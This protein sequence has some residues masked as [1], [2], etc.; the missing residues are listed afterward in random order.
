M[1][2]NIVGGITQD[3]DYPQ[4][5]FALDVYSR[6][7][8]GSL[9]DHLKYSFQDEK[10]SSGEY[11][12]LRSRRPSVRHNLC[13]LVVDD[14]VA[15]LFSEGHFP[16]PVL[17]STVDRDN[18]F[19]LIK[20]ARLNEIMIDAA[21]TGSVGS[22]AIQMR[23]LKQRKSDAHKVFF[24]AHSTDFLTPQFDPACP[25]DLISIREKYKVKGDALRAQGYAIK[26]DDL[27]S[28]FWFCR[29]WTEDAEV[30]YLPW[31]V[32]GDGPSY[33]EDPSK[34][35]KHNLGFVPWVWVRNLPG[36]L[37]MPATGG[38][39]SYSDVD[40][41]CTFLAAIDTMIETEY[42]LSQGGRGMK[43]TM[44]PQLVLKEPFAPSGDDVPRGP[45][46]ALIVDKD[47]DAKLLEIGGSAFTTVLEWVRALREFALE[48]VHGN[49]ADSSKLSA[50]TS[51]R[52]ME[53][54]NQ[55]LIWLADKLRISYGEYAY[56]ELLSMAL[57]AHEKFPL[58][59]EGKQ[60]PAIDA[61]QKITL[62][63]PDWYQPTA[64]D[65]SKKATTVKTLREAHVISRKTAVS[66]ISF[67]FDIEN[68]DDELKVIEADQAAELKMVADLASASVTEQVKVSE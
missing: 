65:L 52:A 9:Y 6:V 26:D 60:L 7:L 68:V 21:T 35:V 4:R 1:F 44:D 32:K 33:V 49:R 62:N 41:S 57:K 17:K 45:A 16:T 37:K 18:L 27:Q 23:V 64:E 67:A 46:N 47:G 14:S 22:V 24:E 53:L 19:S 51:G 5:Q 13:R 8:D 59:V 2:R 25:T 36:K 56:R 12:P 10:T 61:S 58:T 42:L 38:A 20:E 15:L 48:G 34:G 11:V 28:A 29:D 3:K 30:W 50:A 31:L 63:W 40:G 54:M 55:A 39:P 43:Y 66:S